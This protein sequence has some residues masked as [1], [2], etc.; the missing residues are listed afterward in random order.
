M[1]SWIGG[2]TMKRLVFFVLVS[3]LLFALM[4]VQKGD[5]PAV[6]ASSTI[7]QGD[8]IL[9]GNNV[10]TIEGRFDINGSIIVKDNATLRL[11]RAILNFTQTKERQ[12]NITLGN[13]SN[14]CPRLFA[15]NSTITSAYRIDILLKDNSTASFN[16]TAVNWFLSARGNCVLSISNGSYVRW[17]YGYD[18]SVISVSNSTIG[19]WHNYNYGGGGLQITVYDSEIGSLVLGPKSVKC[20][21]S[22][23]EPKR[24]NYWNFIT[25]CSVTLLAG[26][27]SPNITLSNTM[28]NVWRFAFY[29]YSNA[30]IINSVIGEVSAFSGSIIYLNSTTCVHANVY[31]TSVLRITDSSITWLDSRGQSN[32]W[33][34][35][36][37]CAH[38]S[39]Q[40]SAKVY[41]CWYLDV[42]VVDSISQNVPSATV[43]ATYPNATTADSKL[44]DAYGWARLTLTEKITNAT[45]EYP[46]GNYT[47]TATYETHSKST[48]VNMTENQQITLTLDF[49]IPEFP[50][51]TILSFFTLTITLLAVIAYKKKIKIIN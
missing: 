8:L 24:I 31:S 7:F 1:E 38:P 32:T 51:S 19:E 46:I 35:N 37:T 47:I 18:S 12:Y 15:Y 17:Q 34:L 25:N 42:H 6:R 29:G 23:L 50:S 30:A 2:G 10:T 20:T 11:K 45:G 22:N 44:T 5:I 3:S 26:G 33:L 27:A 21:I 41:V 13:P 36:S 28:V 9:T 48:T 40:D 14:G 16:N 49:I 43:T 39:I 4:L